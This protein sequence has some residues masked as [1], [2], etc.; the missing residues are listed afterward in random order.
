MAFQ[1]RAITNRNRDGMRGGKKNGI[2]I[3]AGIGSAHDAAIDASMGREK[4]G[5]GIKGP[6]RRIGEAM[7]ACSSDKTTSAVLP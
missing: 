4:G 3:R 5:R 7:H 1:W 6:R 2:S